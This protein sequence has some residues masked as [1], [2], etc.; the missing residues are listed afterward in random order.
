MKQIL[1]GIGDLL[2]GKSNTPPN[3]DPAHNVQLLQT[4]KQKV[5]TG[6]FTKYFRRP[7]V[8]LMEIVF[9]CCTFLLLGIGIIVYIK[10]GE[11]LKIAEQAG[12][13]ADALYAEGHTGSMISGLEWLCK[14]SA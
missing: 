3:P 1:S 14:L 11:Y 7:Y 6:I 12:E 4:A 13:F 10:I 9:Y 5:E 8:V 2:T